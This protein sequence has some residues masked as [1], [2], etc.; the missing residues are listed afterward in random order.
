M[1]CMVLMSGHILNP[2]RNLWSFRKLP[3]GMDINSDKVTSY[4]SQY[5]EAFL[6]YVEHKYWAN[7]RRAP[8]TRPESIL[9][10]TLLFSDMT[11]SSGQLSYNRYYLTGDDNEDSIPNNVVEYVLRPSDHAARLMTAARL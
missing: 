5:Q 9:N 4:T 11:S 10:N 7:H 2:S 8:V 1:T 6:K 3:Q